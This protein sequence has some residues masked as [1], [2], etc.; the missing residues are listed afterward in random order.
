[1]QKSLDLYNHARSL[2][3]YRAAMSHSEEPVRR[4]IKSQPR[5]TQMVERLKD[6]LFR[7]VFELLDS[8]NDGLITAHH[9]DI[10]RLPLD[11]IKLLE[12]LL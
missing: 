4:Q 8:D 1:M 12:P 2:A 3:E 11:L 10:T 5:S 6:N 9:I 7:Y